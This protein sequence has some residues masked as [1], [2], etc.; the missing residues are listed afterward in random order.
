MAN[1]PIFTST[2]HGDVA[3]V[4]KLLD[5]DATLVTIRDAKNLTPLHVAASRGQVTVAQLLIDHGADVHGLA[6]D[7]EWTPLVFAAYRGHFDVA[8]VLIENGAGITDDDGNPIH[9]SGQRKHKDICRLLVE[10]GAIDNLLDSDDDDLLNLFRA[11]YSYD[12]DAVKEILAR[13]PEL[14]NCKDKNGR[15]ALHEA[16]THGDTKTVR[17][18]LNSGADATIQDANRQT[19]TDRAETHN[20]HSVKK[21]LDKHD[22]A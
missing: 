8:K 21:L 18:L 11:T 4:R 10:H 3:A 16:C 22:A 14:V 12:A 5:D 13:R 6:K 9:Y 15:T 1:H 20:Q 17:A 2:F 7:G 19:P